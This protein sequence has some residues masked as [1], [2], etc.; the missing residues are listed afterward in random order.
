MSKD[1]FRNWTP[2]G[3]L[4]VRYTDANGQED[5]WVTDSRQLADSIKKITLEYMQSSLTLTNR[6]LY[7]QLVAG[8]IIPNADKVYKRVCKF[9]TDLRYGG[10]LDW[11]AIEDRGRIP[12][13]ASQWNNVNSL[14]SSAVYS[15][16]RPRWKDQDYYVEVYCEKQA[17]ES[18]LKPVTEKY[19]TYFGYNKGYSSASTVYELAQRVKAQILN[20]KKVVI[21]YLGDHDPS[22]LDMIRD[23]RERIH[24]FLTQ[25]ETYIEPQF[26]VKQIALNLEQIKKYNPPPNP[27]KI[28][29]PRAKWYIAKYGQSSWELDALKPQV[30]VEL[31]ER[32]VLEY[33]DL[34]KYNAV[35]KL[36]QAEIKKLE[37]FGR[38]VTKDDK[39]DDGDKP[40]VWQGDNS[41][42]RIFF[43]SQVNHSF[44]YD[45]EDA[46]ESGYKK[47][48]N[49]WFC[50]ICDDHFVN[51]EYGK[52]EAFIYLWEHACEEHTQEEFNG[53]FEGIGR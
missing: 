36:E 48:S 13:R 35:I 27:A 19:H 20:G 34:D 25:G 37:D 23:I 2:K 38:K 14:I 45:A 43:L 17:M 1:K 29:D 40:Y 11:Q 21:L 5:Y 33:L 22:G 28:T 16:R 53:W 41:R 6:Q 9:L 7:Y 15:Y 8:A 39:D 49:D 12:I 18:V 10:H 32:A 4:K 51:D 52:E 46:K 44:E 50:P 26:E 24:E 42:A 47:G 31:T 30:L 3:E